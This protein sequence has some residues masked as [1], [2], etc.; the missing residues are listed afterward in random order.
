MPFSLGIFANNIA[1]LVVDNALC[2]EIF[3]KCF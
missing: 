3:V 1:E 2:E